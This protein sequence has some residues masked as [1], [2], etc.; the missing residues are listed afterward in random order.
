MNKIYILIFIFPVFIFGCKPN[1]NEESK[2]LKKIDTLDMN[3]FSKGGDK[4]YSIDSPYSTEGL[5]NCGVEVESDE[6]SGNGEAGDSRKSSA[7]EVP[8]CIFHPRKVAKRC[9][10]K[11]VVSPRC[12]IFSAK[13]KYKLFYLAS[14]GTQSF[15]TNP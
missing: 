8:Q 9:V 2:V 7:E 5:E 4:I 12:Q 6:T 10:G 11:L 15:W 1:L 14:N 3:I 13:D